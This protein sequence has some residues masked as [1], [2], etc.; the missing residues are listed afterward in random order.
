LSYLYLNLLKFSLTSPQ[1]FRESL[2]K[3]KKSRRGEGEVE[4]IL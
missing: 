1:R 2:R 4:E 3:V